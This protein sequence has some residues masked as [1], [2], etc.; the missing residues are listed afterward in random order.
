MCNFEQNARVRYVLIAKSQVI[1]ADSWSPRYYS[2]YQLLKCITGWQSIWAPMPPKRW[3][4]RAS[5]RHDV[6]ISRLHAILV[7]LSSTLTSPFTFKN[8]SRL[9][10]TVEMQGNYSLLVACCC[11]WSVRLVRV[12]VTLCFPLHAPRTLHVPASYKRGAID[13]TSS[14]PLPLWSRALL[15]LFC[16]MDQLVDSEKVTKVWTN[17]IEKQNIAQET[18]FM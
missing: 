16:D 14:L 5:N 1:V 7:T 12:L 2:T 3:H 18:V 10:S 17:I 6:I 4:G 8:S 13:R 9:Q 11:S 15:A